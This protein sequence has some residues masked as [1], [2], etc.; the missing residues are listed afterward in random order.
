MASFTFRLLFFLFNRTS[1]E[2]LV[3]LF[4]LNVNS[5]QNPFVLKV[6]HNVDTSEI[7][8]LKQSAKYP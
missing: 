3:G 7:L 5:V 8:Y 2:V 1:V 4:S 6:P